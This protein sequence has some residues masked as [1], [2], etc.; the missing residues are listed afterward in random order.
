MAFD[1]VL[2]SIRCHVGDA[3]GCALLMQR[4]TSIGS[5]LALASK[6]GLTNLMLIAPARVELLEQFTAA[7]YRARLNGESRCQTVRSLKER[8]SL[9]GTCA[10]S[11]R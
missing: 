10:N 5:S 7:S 2:E 1:L 11:K 3:D 4:H 9:P 8:G 6:G